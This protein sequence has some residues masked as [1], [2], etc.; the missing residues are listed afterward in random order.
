MKSKALFI[1]PIIIIF[2]FLGTYLNKSGVFSAQK[3]ASTITDTSNTEEPIPSPTPTPTPSPTPKP[4][5]KPLTFAQMNAKYGPCVR[6]PVLMYHHIQ[7]PTGQ[8]SPSVSPE[9]FTSQMEYL[10]TKGYTTVST[11]QLI[12]FF[13]SN[14]PLPAKPV[15]ITF[16]DGYDNF[17]NTA[18]PILNQFGYKATM[19]LST[20]LVGNPNYLTWDQIKGINSTNIRFANH[21][22]SHKN[23]H[24]SD[25]VLEAEIGVAQTQLEERGLGAPKTFAYPYGIVGRGVNYLQENGFIL[26]FTTR[27]G[28]TQCAQQSLSLPRT[29]IGNSSLSN[30]GL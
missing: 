9:F 10:Q 30:Y 24:N 16:D 26:A 17:A 12:N 4:T 28:T 2:F 1:I 15:M 18:V 13:N 19:F 21:T 14:T 22:W 27:P 11:D 25:E 29:R 7:D 23:T 3:A 6:L 5:P 8:T 20:G